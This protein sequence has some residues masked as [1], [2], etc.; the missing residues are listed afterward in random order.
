MGFLDR[1]PGV[2]RVVFRKARAY[3]HKVSGVP[4]DCSSSVNLL[5][6]MCSSMR[7]ACRVLGLFTLSQGE[8]F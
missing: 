8:L 2:L 4:R 1:S 5:M 7:K 6:C 3:C